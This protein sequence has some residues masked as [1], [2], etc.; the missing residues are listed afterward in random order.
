MGFTLAGL[1]IAQFI[2]RNFYVYYKKVLCI[3]VTGTTS[4]MW[5]IICT[6]NQNFSRVALIGFTLVGFTSHVVPFFIV[7]F[8]AL[9]RLKSTLSG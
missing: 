6:G 1:H 3:C 8:F 5:I 9:Y 2:L 4:V 7:L